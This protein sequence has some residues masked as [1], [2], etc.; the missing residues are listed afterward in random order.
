MGTLL[1]PFSLVASTSQNASSLSV[2]H[3]VLLT[4]NGPVTRWSV[5]LRPYSNETVAK[6]SYDTP[7]TQH[8]ESVA[9]HDAECRRL[10]QV[11]LVVYTVHETYLNL[12]LSNLDMS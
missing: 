4:R 8:F 11:S 2:A 9:I 10:A 5:V 6:R 3:N 1:Q 12:P 7:K